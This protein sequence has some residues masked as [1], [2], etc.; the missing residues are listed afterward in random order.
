[1]SYTDPMFH[2]RPLVPLVFN[3]TSTMTATASAQVVTVSDA[4]EL[5]VFSRRTEITGGRVKVRTAPNAG[6]GTT[7]LALRNGTATFAVATIGAA[8]AGD[9]V[10][11]GVTAAA[12]AVFA[13]GTD[14]MFLNVVSTATGSVTVTQGNYDVY[15]EQ[16]ELFA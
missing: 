2:A 16:R 15:A 6:A 12:S 7:K 10:A 8:A 3:V 5:P 9:T 4:T 11:L 13:A 1:M 14:E